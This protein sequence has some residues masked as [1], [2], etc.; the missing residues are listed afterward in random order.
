V[1]LGSRFSIV[2]TSALGGLLGG[3]AA[4]ALVIGLT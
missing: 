2:A 4:A 1:G 3:L